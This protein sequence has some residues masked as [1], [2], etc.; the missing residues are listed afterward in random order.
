MLLEAWGDDSG[1]RMLDLG[2]EVGG[3]RVSPAGELA[4]TF[5]LSDHARVSAEIFDGEGRLVARHDAGQ[6]AAGERELGFDDEDFLSDLPAG[7]YQMNVRAVSTYE[8]GDR[9]EMQ[10]EFAM[11]ES[12][13]AILPARVTLG[14]AHPNPFNPSTTLSFSIPAGPARDFTLRI[15]DVRGRMVRELDSGR[16]DA[17]QHERV[18]NGMD[19]RG[20]SVGSGI[21]HY[22]LEVGGESFSDK[23]V[24]V[25]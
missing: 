5:S 23:M 13:S 4:A 18:W 12:R 9:D 21:Y 11:S 15:Y 2:V 10:V 3:L 17:G 8:H 25:K 22:R 6:L 16:I 20:R 7:N 19:D 14:P 24:L 1:L